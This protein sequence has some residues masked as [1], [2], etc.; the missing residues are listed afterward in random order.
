[1]EV[2]LKPPAWA[3][4]L[5]SDLHGWRERPLPV[6]DLAPFT[7]PDDAWFEYAWL[8]A[9]G[10]VRP[11]PGGVPAGNPWWDQACR[12]AGPRWRVDPRVPAPDV[13]AAGRLKGHRL[14]SRHLGPGRCW[15][16]YSP[17]GPDTA[18][19]LILVHDGKGFWHHGRCGPLA[20]ALLAAGDIPPVHLVFL[21]PGRRSEEY[22]FNAAHA[23]F[24]LE[25][26]LPAAADLLCVEGRPRLLGASLGALASAHLALGRPEAFAAVGALSGAFLSGPDDDPPDPF[27]GGE[28][29]LGRVRA[30]AGRD[31]RWHLDCGALEWLLPAHRRLE[32]ALLAGGYEHQ[33]LTRNTGHNWT[34]WRNMLPDA[35]EFLACCR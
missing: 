19:P 6:G 34:A 29:L 3:T 8:D 32:K 26:A 27:A 15:F 7:L 22:A 30:G 17:A 12:L 25:E 33:C 9:D 4:H 10:T 14:D 24:V 20:D 2:E 13:R 11:D 5:M 31:L 21:A 28:W 18:G 1:M 23:D 16:N 35:L